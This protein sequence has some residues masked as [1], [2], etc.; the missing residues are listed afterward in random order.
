[1]SL[2][3]IIV[4]QARRENIMG[5]VRLKDVVASLR[6]PILFTRSRPHK[7]KTKVLPRKAKHK[8]KIHGIRE[9]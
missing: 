9:E 8:K 5:L 1:M 6:K 4:A 7:V 3:L 2:I